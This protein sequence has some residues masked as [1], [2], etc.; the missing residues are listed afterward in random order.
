MNSFIRI[1]NAIVERKGTCYISYSSV[2]AYE[3]YNKVKLNL[4][5]V[6]YVSTGHP[7]TDGLLIEYIMERIVKWDDLDIIQPVLYIFK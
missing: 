7:R 2:K 4:E 3:K 1:D 6:P 5:E